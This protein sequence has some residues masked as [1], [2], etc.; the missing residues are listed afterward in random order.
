M[1]R[2]MSSLQ[3]EGRVRKRGRGYHPSG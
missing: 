1:Y 3:K 2:V